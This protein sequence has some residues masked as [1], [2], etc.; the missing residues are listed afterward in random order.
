M[1]K[2]LVK[3][4]VSSLKEDHADIKGQPRERNPGSLGRGRG[5]CYW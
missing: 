5:R 3:K 2:P 1:Q 4:N